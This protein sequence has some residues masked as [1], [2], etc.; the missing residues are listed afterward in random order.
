MKETDVLERV[1]KPRRLV[2]AWRQVKRNAGAAGIDRMT[3]KEFER[4]K[5]EL[6]R[7][8]WMKL[9]SGQYRFKPARGVLIPKGGSSTKFRKLGIPTVVMDRIVAQS[10]N[11][12]FEEI[13]DLDFTESNFGFRRGK[14]QHQAIRYVQE[15]VVEGYTWCASIDLKSFFDEIPHELILK[16]IRRKIADE[17]LVTLVARAI[18]AGVVVDEK[19]EKSTKGT[20]QG[21][22]L[23]PMLSN[24]VLN[25]MDHELERRGLKYARWADDFVILLKSRRAAE[26][27][28]KNIT[29]YLEDVLGLPVNQEKSVIAR[30]QEVS[31]L[32]FRIYP[33]KIQVSR[34]S[35]EKFKRRVRELTHRNNPL[36]MY[37]AIRELNV[38]LR[39][40]GGYFRIQEFKQI[41]GNTD[42]WI[43]CRLRSMQLA[44][45]KKPRKF[46]RVMISRGF[47]ATHAGK[48][49]VAMRRWQSV[50][51]KEVRMVMGLEWFREMGLVFLD[52]F[53]LA[54]TSKTGT[55]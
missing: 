50:Y 36:P 27:A 45:W 53:T 3:V 52:D 11:S 19:L 48:T 30:M 10:I 21:S 15:G 42:R 7:T 38:Y 26:R 23:S 49:W 35:L 2:E 55:L 16:I 39:G 25:E 14:S 17:R 41:F 22:P 31:F 46:Q 12:V 40:W 24:I 51:R 6:M 29:W 13:F 34:E 43:R 37:Q 20:P 44:K 18:K 1:F 8:I 4:R 28:M 9:K 47:A 54:L 33:N 32:G 5:G